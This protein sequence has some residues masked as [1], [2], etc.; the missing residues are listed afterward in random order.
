MQSIVE[1]SR[2][3]SECWH[4]E[5]SPLNK[6]AV[7]ALRPLVLHA[8]SGTLPPS[9][10]MSAF[11]SAEVSTSPLCASSCCSEH[12]SPVSAHVWSQLASTAPRY[13]PEEGGG[14]GGGDGGAG[15]GGGGEVVSE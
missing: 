11:N 1:S 5:P 12:T 10:V 3:G 8:P 13:Q 6:G 7:G 4:M 2:V 9:D 15:Q 14:E